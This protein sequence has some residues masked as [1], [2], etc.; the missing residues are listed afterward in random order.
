MAGFDGVA[1]DRGPHA[2]GPTA[3]PF[4]AVG[5][6]GA[7]GTVVG[8]TKA[9]EGLVGRRAD[10]VVGRPAGRLLMPSGASPAPGPWAARA[11][12][13]EP[14][15]G[16]AEIRHG[17]GHGV[18]LLLHVSPM[19]TGNGGTDW[20]VSAAAL[21]DA[22]SSPGPAAAAE[23]A[24]LARSPIGL[25]FWDRALR[26]VWLNGA[27]EAQ[28]GVPRRER[29]GRRVTE[30]RDTGEAAAVEAVME[31]VLDT[32]VPV[33]DH[34]SRWIV[35]GGIPQGVFS[36]SYFRLDGEDGR[37]LGVCAMS[38]DVSGSW[39]RER[40][41]VLGEAGTRIGTTL[42]VMHTAQELADVAVPL[43]ADYV[44]V[45]LSDSVP[46]GSEPLGSE[47]LGRLASTAQSI[48]VFRR[49]GVASIH[50][51]LPE[52]LWPVG[53]AVF[54]PPS[55]P[56]T[57]VLASRTSH[58]EPVLDTSPG[59][60]LDNDPDRARAIAATGMHSLIVVPL[61]ARGTVL[62]VAVFVRTENLAPFTRD[63]LLLAEDL[64]ARASLSLDNARRYTQERTAA[65]AL[66]RSLLPRFLSGGSAV[67]IASRYLPT[68]VREGVGGDWFDVI[69]L[70]GARVALVVGDVV[71]HG[72]AAAATMGQL[73][74]A[75]RTLADMD[76]PPDELL[77]RLDELIVHLSEGDA[78]DMDF[79]TPVMSGT[80]VYAVY[81]PVGRCCTVALA[82][83]PPPAIVSPDG[84]VMFPDLPAGTPI[85]LGLAS[86][87]SVELE[88]AP[89]S[90]IALYS[91][92]L[93][94]S[95]EADI[96]AGLARLGTALS[97]TGTSLENLCD[98]VVA[99]MTARTAWPAGAVLGRAATTAPS[100]DDVA[101]LLARTRTLDADQVASFDLRRDPAAVADARSRTADR[102]RSWGLGHLAD[103]AQLVVSELVTNALRYGT[104][105]VRL[106]LIRHH[107]LV[108]EVSDAD[109][110]TP[111]LRRP[112]GLS[113]S[114]WG[115]L[116]V[117]SLAD[118]WGSRLTADGK[119]V[120]AELELPP[121][122]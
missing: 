55:S 69:P 89:G 40:L 74:T 20:L 90:V 113:E 12:E 24:L 95:R 102:L 101:L 81:D 9:A 34:A 98:E 100:E 86:F 1:P 26:C 114:G 97:R 120:W 22:L 104:G 32:G 115:L 64:G 46:L 91:D 63:D 103:T 51:A 42:D 19:S 62:G 11:G 83:H 30:T 68:D 28:D 67:E 2:G 44:T 60:W 119:I 33:V 25:S 49:A 80:C 56:F 8:W 85:G 45:D 61:Q 14:W 15:T 36:C 92:G 6:I 54:V 70:P 84:R 112:R 57:K 27:A 47:P 3:K 108:C 77:A 72:I 93:V 66:Q 31:R 76:L 116:L 53:E 122:S 73:R 48:P 5:V 59:T 94:E 105:T 35:P 82:G 17:E 18:T 16:M 38:V 109:T 121:G 65:L 99:T 4:V 7:D 43:L 79:T 21:S 106:R 13:R 58:F 117:S 50:P 41:A 75:V 78:G 110:S 39:A 96:D 10:D 71:G 118:R 29:L 52:S 88:L 107:S 87:E 111:R 37:P 23:A